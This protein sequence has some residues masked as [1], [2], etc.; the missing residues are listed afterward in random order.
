MKSALVTGATRG[1]GLGVA[2]RLAAQGYDLTITARDR[3]SLAVV[4]DRLRAEGARDV[5]SVAIDLAAEDAAEALAGTHENRYGGMNALILNAGVGTA[6]RIED[7]PIGRYHKTVAVNLGAPFAL[8]QRCLPL[9]RNAV[10]EN[11][12]S[13]AKVIALGSIAGVYAEAGLGVYGATKAALVSL[14]ETLNAEESGNG[15]SGTAVAPAFVDTDMSAWARESVA[16]EEMIRVD[17]IVEIV[18]ML[19]RL[20]RQAVVPKVVVTRAGTDGFRA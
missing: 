2:S 17:D 5:A 19:L 20:S 15:I 16:R 3:E 4:A 13:G 10:R 1:I 7:Y 8:L 18:D 14:I 9:L 6:G 11:A 12:V